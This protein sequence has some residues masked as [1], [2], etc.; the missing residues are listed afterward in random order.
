M[1]KIELR[2]IYAKFHKFVFLVISFQ[3]A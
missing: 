3:G 2:L 1:V